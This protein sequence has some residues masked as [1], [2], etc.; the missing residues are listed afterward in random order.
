MTNLV[1]YGKH[2]STSYN[3]KQEKERVVLANEKCEV[4]LESAL[5]VKIEGN[6]KE[7]KRDHSKE[8][9]EE[10]SMSAST[11]VERK[12]RKQ[13]FIAKFKDVRRVSYCTNNLNFSLYSASCFVKG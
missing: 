4:K 2:I 6:V 12:E 11:I 10:K 13:S 5:E 1:E 3:K 7:K 9:S 8:L